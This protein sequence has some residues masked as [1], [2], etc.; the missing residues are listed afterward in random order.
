MNPG[1]LPLVVIAAILI[2]I[3]VSWPQ[4]WTAKE[5][6][7]PFDADDETRGDWEQ[8]PSQGHPPDAG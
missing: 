7:L 3:T 4:F 6:K 1:V 8:V 2:T 5:H